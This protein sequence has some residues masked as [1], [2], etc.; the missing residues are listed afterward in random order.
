MSIRVPGQIVVRRDSAYWREDGESVITVFDDDFSIFSADVDDSRWEPNENVVSDSIVDDNSP[1]FPQRRQSVV[2]AAAPIMDLPRLPRRRLTIKYTSSGSSTVVEEE[3]AKKNA[4][5]PMARRTLPLRARGLA[6]PKFPSRKRSMD[7]SPP[8]SPSQAACGRQ[9][10]RKCIP[11][12]TTTP[13]KQNQQ[14]NTKS[15]MAA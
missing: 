12:A 1:K 9:Y 10:N 11:S 3:S 8:P 14:L 4:L 7:S 15:A 13:P 5:P 2:L 6:P